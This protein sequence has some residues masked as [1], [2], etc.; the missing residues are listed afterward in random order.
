MGLLGFPIRGITLPSTWNGSLAS[1]AFQ[2]EVP[3][4]LPLGV[5]LEPPGPPTQRYHITFHLEWILGLLGLP[6]R[7]TTLPP[8]WSGSWPANQRCQGANQKFLKIIAGDRWKTLAW[9][10][11]RDP[12]TQMFR[13]NEF[14]P[15]SFKYPK[16]R[17]SHYYDYHYYTS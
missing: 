16:M 2:S 12:R 15:N 10:G 1:W 14:E 5:D 17:L 8:T 9:A 11:Q 6:I 4:Y 7:G 13:S 3:L